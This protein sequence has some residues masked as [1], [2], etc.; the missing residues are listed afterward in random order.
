MEKVERVIV[1]A[2][3]HEGAIHE[4]VRHEDIRARLWSKERG[5][6]RGYEEGFTTSTER[7]VDR[8]EA[9][10]IAFAA[11]QTRSKLDFLYSEDIY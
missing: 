11:G 10:E 9:A 4:G 3:R 7:F 8:K 2:I 6:A 1:A 5:P